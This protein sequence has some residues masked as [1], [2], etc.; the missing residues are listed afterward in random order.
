MGL[1]VRLSPVLL[2]AGLLLAAGGAQADSCIDLRTGQNYDCSQSPPAAPAGQPAPSQSQLRD[3]LRKSLSRGNAQ[4]SS[5][6]ADAAS[7]RWS[8]A[9]NRAM[10]AE[11]SAQLTNDPQERAQLMAK[12]NAA[13]GDM[14]A[15]GNDMLAGTTDPAARAQLQDFL[16]K[17]QNSLAQQATA[18]GFGAPPASSAPPQQA[19]APAAPST[20]A[21]D[22]F[23]VCEDP[24]QGVT[25]C[26][27][28][29]RTGD[30]CQEVWY[31]GGQKTLERG[32]KTC[33]AA[34][35]QQRDAYFA[36]QP[37][38]QGAPAD[39]RSQQLQGFM[40]SLSPYCQQQLKNYL[41]S[42]RDSQTSG[43][44]AQAAMQA[45][46]NLQDTGGG[47]QGGHD[48]CAA[49]FAK[50]ASI[51]GVA[52]PQRRLAEASRKAWGAAMADKP[53]ETVNVPDVSDAPQGYYADG[54]GGGGWDPGEVLN[55]GAQILGV[56]G[57]ILGGFAEGYGSGGGY[58]SGPV[59]TSRPTYGYGGPSGGGYVYRGGNS[60][61]S[62]STITGTHR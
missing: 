34:D 31:Q 39:P 43:Q 40:A 42:S 54:S 19:A 55:A 47:T 22:T 24:K 57:A 33:S 59:Y 1:R 41:Y 7:T 3:T 45:F 16:N 53:R 13:M 56:L 58:S 10:Q 36:G 18:S 35:M 8:D 61:G 49:G 29:G 48:N 32:W 12:Y 20:P 25:T 62:N 51:L 30:Q 6:A 11:Q 23:S 17:S 2:T 15:A 5:A 27:E 26:Y 60:G 21:S 28:M 44:A 38:G 9:V 50:L 46:A 14:R 52:V 37:V 4:G